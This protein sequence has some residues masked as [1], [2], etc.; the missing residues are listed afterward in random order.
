[1]KRAILIFFRNVKNN[2]KIF[3]INL[4]GFSIGITSVLF[5]YL[6]SFKELSTD[7]F[8]QKHG[9]L[10]RVIEN[11]DGNSMKESAT[12]F[13]LGTLLKKHFPEV[14]EY[15]RYM[16]RP[17]EIKVDRSEFGAMNLCFVDSTFF[18][19]FDFKLKLGD[20]SQLYRT[21]DG[22]IITQELASRFFNEEMPLGKEIEV[23]EPGGGASKRLVVVGVLKDYPEESTLKPK[24][25]ANIESEEKKYINDGWHVLASQLFLYMP[26][27]QDTKQIALQISGLIANEDSWHTENENEFELQPFDDIYLHSLNVNDELKKGNFYLVKILL[28]IGVILLLITS[29][30]Y[31]I[32]NL[33]VSHKNKNYKNIHLVLGGNNYSMFKNIV[34][35]SLTFSSIAFLIVLMLYPAAYKVITNFTE[36]H[37]SLYTHSHIIIFVTFYLILIVFGIISGALQF[38]FITKYIVGGIMADNVFRRQRFFNGLIQIQ[39]VVFIIALASLFLINRQVNYIRNTDLGFDAKNTFTLLFMGENDRNLFQQEFDKLSYINSIAK[40]QQLFRSSYDYQEITIAES[41]KDIEAQVIQGDNNYLE[42]YNIKLLAGENLNKRDIPETQNEFMDLI[43]KKNTVV[44]DVLVNQEFIKQ[45]GLKEP[46]GSIIKSHATGNAR[47]V[48]II[49]NVKNLPV[50]NT[51]KPMIIGY[52]L[53]YYTH[54]LV[55]S[56]QDGLSSRFI[57]DATDFYQEQNLG[58]YIDMLIWKYDFD[59]EYRNEQT[60]KKLVNAFSS[61]LLIVMILGLIGLSLFIAETKIK[62]IGIRKVN[63]AKVS[64]IL[65]M[66]NK[67]FVK[68]I[69]IAFVIATP[70]AYYVMNKWLESFAYKTNLSWWIFALAGLLA[71]GIALLTVSWQ[72]WRAATRNPVEALRYE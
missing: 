23:H 1:M 69:V 42:T 29:L 36:F 46:L 33:G 11:H 44:T 22:A 17:Y 24:I 72:S 18:Q 26:E 40:G 50:Y 14:N 49:D 59:K 38:L 8:H 6:Y 52:N 37:Y 62:E 28:F 4:L 19:L 54:S 61:V 48:G 65:A 67:D 53:N 39:L 2:P 41:N 47:I 51:L 27:C 55:V 64:E 68:W 7:R 71:L 10:Y 15:S 31:V 66:L 70:I 32:L 25:I 45:S 21:P 57:S 13:P 58:S 60:L 3:S 63:G 35:N 56:V 20:Y 43:K 5:I 34:G 30:N 16:E 9:D 12:Y